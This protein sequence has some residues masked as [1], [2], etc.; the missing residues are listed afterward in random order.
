MTDREYAIKELGAI[1][2]MVVAM[3]KIV[4]MIAEDVSGSV[5]D[6]LGAQEETTAPAQPDLEKQIEKLTNRVRELSKE[7]AA[8]E[9]EVA[10]Q[11]GSALVLESDL[12]R[13]GEREATLLVKIADLE[14]QLRQIKSAV[15]LPET[16]TT[17]G[18]TVIEDTE[19]PEEPEEK[20]ARPNKTWHKWTDEEDSWIRQHLNSATDMEV[21]EKFGVSR[22]AAY[23][24]MCRIRDERD[25]A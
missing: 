17:S 7:N 10:R 8:L 2:G 11:K 22:K 3:A 13:A 9:A 14:E 20:K 16:V 23:A 6:L 15:I 24:R 12:H 21:A 4:D 19:E 18:F 5:A 25:E 1:D